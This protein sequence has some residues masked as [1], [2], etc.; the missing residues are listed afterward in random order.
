MQLPARTRQSPGAASGMA[1]AGLMPGAGG[2][3]QP[4][5]PTFS[6]MLFNPCYWKSP[7]W[8]ILIHSKDS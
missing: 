3:V 1:R 7:R 2:L 4:L 6:V 5:H 8:F